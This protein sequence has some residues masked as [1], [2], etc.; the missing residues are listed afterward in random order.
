METRTVRQCL[1]TVFHE[2]IAHRRFIERDLAVLEA[3]SA[4]A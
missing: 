4:T 2:H 1:R 3:R